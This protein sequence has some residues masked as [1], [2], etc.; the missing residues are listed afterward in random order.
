MLIMKGPFESGIFNVADLAITLSLCI[1][2]FIFM[3][4][5]SK[6]IYPYMAD[7]FLFFEF[8]PH[9]IARPCGKVQ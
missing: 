3:R 5:K 4:S 1:L 7:D 8:Q 9:R 6:A 2:F